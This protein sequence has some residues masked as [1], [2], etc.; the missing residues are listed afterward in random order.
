MLCFACTT[1]LL[2]FLYIKELAHVFG[3]QMYC[4]FVWFCGAKIR[5]L[6]ECQLFS[7]KSVIKTQASGSLLWAAHSLAMMSKYGFLSASVR[8]F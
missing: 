3:V 1:V 2:Y 8:V 6:P 4:L 5:K 7:P